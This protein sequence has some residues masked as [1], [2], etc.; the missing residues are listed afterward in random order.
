MN[1]I[2]HININNIE[3]NNQTE[4]K[5]NTYF[6][7]IFIINLIRR[8]DR[9][10]QMINKLT[11]AN[12]TNYEFVEAIDGNQEPYLSLY[13]AKIKSSQFIESAGAFGILFS[14]LKVLI[15]SKMRKYKKI[16]I[17]ED[18]AIFHKDFSI[19]FNNRI[20]NIPRWKLLYF[21]TSMHNWRFKERCLFNQSNYYLK[22]EGTIPGAFAIG[23]DESIF[24]ELIYYI[25]T[26]MKPWDLEPLRNI[27]LKYHN[28][29]II[30]YPYLIIAQ[31]NDSNIRDSKSLRDNT[32]EC[33]WDL[34]LYDI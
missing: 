1:N 7:R 31:T 13:N 34:T 10:E 29:V 6:D 24:Q 32:T 3:Q 21:G 17:L 18:D 20:K 11:K 15:Y 22:S 27:N 9:K 26:S 8:P 2:E 28:E 16:L 25:R 30:F 14:A 12:I 5:I 33:N 23:I 19:T 4:N